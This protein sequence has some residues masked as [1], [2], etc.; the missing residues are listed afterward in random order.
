MNN[1]RFTQLYV[2]VLLAC[3]FLSSCDKKRQYTREG[4]SLYSKK[5]YSQAIEKYGQALKK[6]STF[7]PA[8]YN[9]G[10]AYYMSSDSNYT[11]AVE[12]YGKFLSRPIGKTHKDSLAFANA[13]YN[14]G[15]AFFNLS[16]INTQ[17]SNSGKYLKQAAKDYQASLLLDSKDT[18]AKYNL[19]LCLWLMK[20]NNQNNNEQNNQQMQ[21]MLDAMKI[22]EKKILE[23]TKTKPQ[24]S[25][26]PK[27]EKDW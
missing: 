1:L 23:K 9:E 7:A 13:L 4:N 16:Q 24:S 21:Q 20:N 18:N 12:A 3:L 19:A 5:S 26:R 14:R 15:N 27:N 17:D 6:D 10:N 11:A 25:S 8:L 2:M 22:N